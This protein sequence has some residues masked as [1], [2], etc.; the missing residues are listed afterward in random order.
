MIIRIGNTFS[1]EIIE[2][3]LVN[4]LRSYTAVD[5]KKDKNEKE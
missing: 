3:R 2:F 4:I 5:P 1:N